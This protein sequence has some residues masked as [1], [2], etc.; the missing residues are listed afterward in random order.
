MPD[1]QFHVLTRTLTLCI[2]LQRLDEEVQRTMEIMRT[3]QLQMGSEI[4]QPSMRLKRKYRAFSVYVAPSSSSRV[5]RLLA[6]RKPEPL[7]RPPPAHVLT[8][9][10]VL[11]IDQR[12]LSTSVGDWLSSPPCRQIVFQTVQIVYTCIRERER[13][14]DLF[15]AVPGAN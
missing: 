13:E 4:P 12:L 11:H 3:W 10:R 5:P 9:S 1:A 15:N 6:A 2:E 8:F 14:R 7:A